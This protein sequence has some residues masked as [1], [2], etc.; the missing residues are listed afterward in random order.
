MQDAFVRAGAR[1]LTFTLPEL[2]EIAPIARLARSRMRAMNEALRRASAKTGARLVDFERIPWASDPRLWSEDRLHANALGHERIAQALAGA[3][4]LP[5]ASEAWRAPLDPAPRPS[6]AERARRE[7][8]WTS[9]YL[10]PWLARHARGRSSGDGRGPK[11]PDL[12]PLA[13]P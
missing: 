2:S 6:L 12:L 13:S 11:R 3:A 1:V 7:W 9:D 10:C 8:R 4:E 5:G